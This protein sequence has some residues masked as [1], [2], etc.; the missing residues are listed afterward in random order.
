MNRITFP[1]FTCEPTDCCYNLKYTISESTIWPAVATNKSTAEG[2]LTNGTR[3]FDPYTGEMGNYTYF[4]HFKNE[5]GTHIVSKP[6]KVE[7]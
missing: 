1:P 6:I 3:Y 4:V 7:V 2:F 5:Y